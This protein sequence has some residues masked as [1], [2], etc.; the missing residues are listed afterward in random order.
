MEIVALLI[1]LV[2]FEAAAWRWGFD[3]SD[4][5]NSREWE[6]RHLWTRVGGE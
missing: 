1:V 4:G 3:S 2:A 6:R 5:V